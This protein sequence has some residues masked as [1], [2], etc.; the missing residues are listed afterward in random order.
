MKEPLTEYYKCVIYGYVTGEQCYMCDNRRK[1]TKMKV[2]AR[3]YSADDIRKI[4][5]MEKI[6][7]KHEFE[8]LLETVQQFLDNPELKAPLQVLKNAMKY[9]KEKL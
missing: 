6:N 4:K 8:R 9:Y 1:C 3:K 7:Y 2:F 5:T